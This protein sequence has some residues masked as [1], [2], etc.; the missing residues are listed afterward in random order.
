MMGETQFLEQVFRRTSCLFG[1]DQYGGVIYHWKAL[2]VYF[3]MK[4]IALEKAFFLPKETRKPCKGRGNPICGDG[5]PKETQF[6][7]VISSPEL[8]DSY[9]KAKLFDPD[10]DYDSDSK[11]S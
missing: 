11:A 7:G 9:P 3:S 5:F 2:C 4:Q 1:S 6:L 10:S 8:S